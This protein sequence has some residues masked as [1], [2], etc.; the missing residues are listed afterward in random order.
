MAN[1][2]TDIVVFTRFSKCRLPAIYDS[3]LQLI[4]RFIVAKAWQF[5]DKRDLHR[6]ADQGLPWRCL[7]RIVAFRD[8]L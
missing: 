5:C 7:V 2:R 8:N 3:S 1:D 4:S 6:P